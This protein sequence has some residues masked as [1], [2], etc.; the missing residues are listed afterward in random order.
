MHSKKINTTVTFLYIISFIIAIFMAM[1]I[2]S[3]F[4]HKTDDDVT[5]YITATGE[6]YH[7][8]G[9]V[10]LSQSSIKTTLAKAKIN[11]YTSCMKCNV[12][13][14]SYLISFIISLILVGISCAK[15]K[16]KIYLK[17][18]QQNK[19]EQDATF[20]AQRDNY[21]RLYA[22]KTYHELA[23]IPKD[24]TFD[25]DGAPICGTGSKYGKYSVYVTESGKCYHYKKY[26]SSAVNEVH[27]FATISYG[28]TPCTKCSPKNVPLLTIPN[29]Y[30]EYKKIFSIKKK[31]NI[32]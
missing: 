18:E 11:G 1:E 31:Y 32:E 21:K 15:I 6:K 5:C 13:T 27:V 24:V 12:S 22:G 8:S 10:Y 20:Q 17:E 3:V 30:S 7:S 26:C 19:I 25:K 16:N 4:F 29:W 2:N 23:N 9:C 14:N 28:Y